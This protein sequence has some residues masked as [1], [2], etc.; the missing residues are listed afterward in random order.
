MTAVRYDD[1]SKDRNGW[2]LGLS[3]AQLAAVAAGGVPELVALGSR[4]WTFSAAWLP[5]WAL[6]AAMVVL[7]VRGRSAARWLVD[8]ILYAWGVCLGWTEWVSRAATGKPGNPAEA[9]LPGVLGGIRTHDGPPFGPTM[10]RPV[11]VQDLSARTWAAIARISHPG[12]GLAE[13]PDRDRM[14]SGLAELLEVAARTELVDVVAMQVR[15]VPD[16]GVE[17][18]EWVVGHRHDTAPPLARQ[19]TQMLGRTLTSA[20]VRVEAFVTV[21]VGED[22]IGRQA[23][24]CGG[25]MDGR[26]RVLYGAMAEVESRLRGAMGCTEVDWL[27]SPELAEVV[28]TGFAPGD[29]A[30]LVAASLESARTPG[31]ATGVPMAAAAATRASTEVRHY[32]HDAWSTVSYTVLLPDQGAVIGA[33]APVFVPTVPGER[34]CVTV[35]YQPLPQARAVRLV[36]REEMSASTGNELRYRMG[37]RARPRQRRDTARVTSQDEKLAVGRAL[38]RCAA[39]AAV[40]VPGG[41]PVSEYGRDMEA[42]IRAAGFIPQ[43][44]DLAQDSG[45]AAA[46]VPLGIGLPQRRVAR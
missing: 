7:P 38:V 37:F 24:E 2:F 33:L 43:R 8:L 16:D 17:R 22:R 27:G 25:G 21:V 34:R 31:V 40:T 45:F 5:A 12:I 13:Q 15:T 20:A 9:D 42:S 3:G 44:L 26:A 46:C 32:V 23:R 19:V 4:N 14:G 18:A 6:T 11:V 41:W 1:Y 39:V 29:R 35:F 10:A 30:G 28:R 36:G